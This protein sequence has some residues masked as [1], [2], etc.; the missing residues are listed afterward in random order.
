MKSEGI[1]LIIALDVSESMLTQDIAPSRL[2]RAK[3]FTESL[4]KNS[5]VIELDLLYLQETPTCKF[6]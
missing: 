5:G 4:I 6:L 1:D 3:K 2:E